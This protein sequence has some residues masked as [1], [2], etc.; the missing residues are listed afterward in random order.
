MFSLLAKD[1]TGVMQQQ[2]STEKQERL[3]IKECL[4]KSVNLSSSIKA[5]WNMG[6]LDLVRTLQALSALLQS[7]KIKRV[8]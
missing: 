7:Q 6:Q 8:V 1:G 4:T 3:L 5:I 2:K